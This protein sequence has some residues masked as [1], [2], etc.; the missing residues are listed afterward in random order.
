MPNAKMKHE[1]DPKQEILEQLGDIS[2]YELND[3]VLIATYKR[4]EKTLGGIII[5]QSNLNED[6][7][8]SKAGLV[9]KIGPNA[10]PPE[11]M[12]VEGQTPP[13]IPVK[14]YDWVVIRPSDGW[15]LEVNFVHC[16][17]VHPKFIRSR[18][19]APGMVW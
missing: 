6:M 8:Q 3:E 5:A 15:A 9:V 16:R 4:P 14:L 17:H 2:G 1:K 19:P 13:Y 10:Y 11:L 7:F 18:T 12:D